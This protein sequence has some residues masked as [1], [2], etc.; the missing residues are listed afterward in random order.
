MKPHVADHRHADRR[1]QAEHLVDGVQPGLR[2]VPDRVAEPA[3]LDAIAEA[4]HEAIEA[5][6]EYAMSSPDP[7]VETLLEGVYAP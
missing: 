1:E 4:T 2:P 6:V 5:A 3:E 7:S